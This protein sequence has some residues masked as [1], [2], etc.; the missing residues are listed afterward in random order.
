MKIKLL[1]VLTMQEWMLQVRL[2]QKKRKQINRSERFQIDIVIVQ[3]L[4][5][6]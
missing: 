5:L 4:L 2:G 1:K 3:F 6:I